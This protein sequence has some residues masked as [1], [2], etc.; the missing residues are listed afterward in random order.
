MLMLQSRQRR[1]RGECTLELLDGFGVNSLAS[2]PV[3]SPA[4]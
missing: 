2:W 3:N 1:K 4:Q